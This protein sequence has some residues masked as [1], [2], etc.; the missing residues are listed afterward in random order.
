MPT[1]SKGQGILILV[2][3]SLFQ[4]SLTLV[5]RGAIVPKDGVHLKIKRRHSI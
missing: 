4:E 2:L 3:L 5:S 1:H